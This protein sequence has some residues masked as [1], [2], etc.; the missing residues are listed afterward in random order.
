MLATGSRAMGRFRFLNGTIADLGIPTDWPNIQPRGTFLAILFRGKRTLDTG[1]SII[2]PRIYDSGAR[3]P[4]IPLFFFAGI[5]S[6]LFSGVA[7]RKNFI[8][9]YRTLIR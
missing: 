9:T 3:A 2:F 6:R 8:N 5:S 7:I 4:I 1:R